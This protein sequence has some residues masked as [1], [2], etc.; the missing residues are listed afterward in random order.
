[1]QYKTLQL[2]KFISKEFFDLTKKQ[3][4]EQYDLR[5]YKLK[6]HP[7][8]DS[9]SSSK[10]YSIYCVTD[11]V[12]LEPQPGQ[13]YPSPSGAFQVSDKFAKTFVVEAEKYF[14]DFNLTKLKTCFK[15][16]NE[17]AQKINQ[18]HKRIKNKLNYI[19]FD[20]F[21]TTSSFGIIKNNKLYWG[22]IADSF[23][24]IFDKNGKQ[25]FISPDGWRFMKL[26]K[27]LEGKDRRIYIRK[28]LR[29]G[30]RN[31]KKIGYGVITGEDKAIKYL[32]TGVQNL[33]KGDLV[34]IGTDGYQEYIK[35]KKFINLFT[36]WNK[37]IKQRINNLEKVL[38]KKSPDKF[39]HERTMFVIKI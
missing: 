33:K 39:G 15:K 1:M 9:Y 5:D 18:K 35:N 26:P 29:N 37:D 17:Q 25:K 14:N 4:K 3:L 6:M 27:N 16:G 8:E 11:G 22:V 32:D 38:I 10:K 19:D 23:V 34:F 2:Y 28:Y 20:L 36:K 21:A 7:R 13:R 30:F 31:N 24:I 12:T